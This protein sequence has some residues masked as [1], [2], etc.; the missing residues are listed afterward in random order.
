MATLLLALEF[1]GCRVLLPLLGYYRVLPNQPIPY[2]VV[3]SPGALLF[4]DWTL[5]S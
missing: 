4:C 1:S 2:L 3:A 5:Q